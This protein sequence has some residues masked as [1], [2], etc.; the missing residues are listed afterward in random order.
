MAAWHFAGGCILDTRLAGNVIQENL[1]GEF[2]RALGYTEVN[3][4]FSDLFLDDQTLKRLNRQVRCVVSTHS[5]HSSARR[6]GGEQ[7]KM[8]S[9]DVA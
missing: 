4:G 5:V 1:S 6:S 8:S 3:I 9:A 2:Q 7:R